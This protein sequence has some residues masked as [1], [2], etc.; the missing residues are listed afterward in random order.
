MKKCHLCGYD[1]Q[2][3]V[4]FCLSC[5]SNLQITPQQEPQADA[6][7]NFDNT[8]QPDSNPQVEQQ[9][10]PQPNNQQSTYNQYDNNQYNNGPYNNGQYNNGQYNPGQNPY[11]G[12]Y[13][14]Q[15]NQK[16]PAL[17]ALL[18]GIAGFFIYLL[19]GIGQLYLGLIK[20]GIVL[21]LVGLVPIILNFLVLNTMLT[22][23]VLVLGIAYVVYC[24]YDAYVCAKAINEGM[25][26]PLLFGI[27][28]LQ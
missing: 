19:G 22:L 16:N 13:N 10:I 4:Q 28:D 11:P 9:D 21:C 15:V 1:N 27:L 5:G 18:S 26:I 24:A 7:Q 2:D 3:N 25:S 23:V 6:N 14:A 8:Y 20:R 12:G 17:A